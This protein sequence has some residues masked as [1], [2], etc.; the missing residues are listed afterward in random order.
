MKRREDGIVTTSSPSFRHSLEVEID[1]RLKRFAWSDDL[2]GS[3]I[4]LDPDEWR[5]LIEFTRLL[6]AMIERH[7]A[8]RA[9]PPRVGGYL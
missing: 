6:D 4:P 9:L 7:P 3:L 8:R 2:G 1:G 5:R